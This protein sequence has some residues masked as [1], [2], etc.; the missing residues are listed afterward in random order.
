VSTAPFVSLVDRIPPSNLEAEMA[1]LGSVLVDKEM[2]AAVSEIVRPSDFYAS[3]HETIYLALYALYENGKPLDKV[4]LA[5]ELRSRGML[6]KIGGLSYLSSLMETVPTAASAEYYAKIV[7]EKASLRGL[8]HA[9][10]R[11]TQLGYESEDDVPAALDESEQIVYEVGNRDSR[12]AFSPV[13]S[14]LLDTFHELEKRHSQRGDRTGVTSGFNDIDDYT[15]GF[16]KGNLI[17]LAARPAMGKTSLA[18]N[19]AL[20]GAREEAAPVAVFSLEMTKQELVERL[21]SSDAGIDATKLR[22][23]AIEGKDW[24]RI[25]NSIGRLNELQLFL[26]DSGS[27]TVTEIRSRLRRLKS[28]HGLAIAYIDYLQLVRPS[29]LGRNVNRNE[30][31]SEICRT[32]KATAKDL[33]IPIVA[34]A[35]LNR[36][37]ETRQD[38]RPM[39]SDLRDCLAGSTLVTNADTGERISMSDIVVHGKR[40]NV[41]AMDERMCLVRRPITDAWEVGHKRVFDV[42]TQSG[43]R[44]RCTAGHRFRT[45]AGWSEL[46]DLAVGEPIAAPRSLGAASTACATMTEGQS[47][48]LG[49]LIGDGHLGG[50]P[51]LTVATQAEADLA[52]ELARAEFG[53]E[54]IIKPER[55]GTSAMRVVLT[56]GRLCGAGKNPLTTWLRE[57]GIWKSTGANKSVPAAMFGQPDSVVAAF[58]RGL[59]HADGSLS[60]RPSTSA[61][62]R[63]STISESLAR[64]VQH[65]LLRFGINAILKADSRNIGGYRTATS[66]MWTLALMER[67]AVC[68]SV[69]TIGFLGD[70]HARALEKVVWE[71]TNDASQFDRIPLRTNEPVRSLRTARGLSHAALGWRDQGKAMSRS[72][73]AQLAVRLDDEILA[74]LAYSDILWDPIRSIEPAG[75]ELVYDLTVGELHNFVVDD[76]LTHNSGAIEQEADIVTFLYR[77]AYYNKE[78]SPEPDLTE[79]IFAKHRN[80][81]TGTVKLRF[82]PEHTLF[83]PYGDDTHFPAP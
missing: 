78:T 56:T 13:S 77:D 8:I 72:T 5:E 1:L 37:V 60:R 32:L 39:L 2:M 68:K 73:C 25:G 50:S 7:R 42:T 3:L 51:A 33:E 44:I 67:T 61:T 76:I 15:A 66:C 17:I 24:E 81:R 45:V 70:K 34:L 11:I 59:F 14:L 31:L 10:T 63:L 52:A 55:A 46:R 19:M 35:Q 27:V 38:K 22:R 23:G 21:I 80:G 16:Q 47:L 74:G 28:T 43:R 62:V 6:E 29:A 65:L 71:K 64:G 82:R 53:L 12:G 41:W 57:L 40:F 18:L 83:Q 58:L 20:F 49:W 54:P 9:G 48:L 69:D 75:S 30:E 26:D 36:A 4:A 79:L